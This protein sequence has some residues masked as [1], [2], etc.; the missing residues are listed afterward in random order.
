M[1]A[2]AK[3]RLITAAVWTLRV[4]LG[5]VFVVS[6]LAKMIDP[7]GTLYKLQQYAEAWHIHEPP[8]GVMLIGG[9]LLS[10]AEFIS[11][12]LLATGSLRRV[13]LWAVTAIM[14]VMTPLS[15]YIAV[16]NPVDHC[17]CFG[18]FLPIS[19]VAT[20]VKNLVIVAALVPLWM[21]NR[22]VRCLYHPLIQW[23]QILIALVYVII[24]GLVGYHEQPMIDFRPFPVG[25]SPVAETDLSS[26]LYRYRND[27][28]GQEQTFSADSLPDEADGWSYIERVD[29]AT[30]DASST[31]S[32][33]DDEGNDVTD[34][35]IGATDT[36]L[37]VMISDLP[38]AGLSGCYNINELA[39]AICQEE[40]DDALVCVVAGD[41]A[42]VNQWIDLSMPTYPVVRAEASAIRTVARGT[43]AVVCLRDGVIAWKR[44]LNAINLDQL[45]T[46]SPNWD[47]YLTDGPRKFRSLTL[48]ALLLEA[49]L[50]MLTS[51]GRLLHLWLLKRKKITQK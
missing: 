4:A 41:D 48:L 5:A 40:G 2:K 43:V 27:A 7:Y 13:S 44:N 31:F 15:L 39:D 32:V 38:R 17:G 6:G 16:A 36:Q 47:V 10:V 49:L 18:D 37:L 1:T 26:A 50:W 19:N 45:D 23:L 3:E 9:C 11:G 30:A 34:L 28:T 21:W 29:Q 8:Y 24:V 12:W 14:A 35:L 42:T 20:L 33:S 46:D 51:G 22:R 25:T